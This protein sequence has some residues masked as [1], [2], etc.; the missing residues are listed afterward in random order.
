MGDTMATVYE[1]ALKFALYADERSIDAWFADLNIEE[2][3]VCMYEHEKG[4]CALVEDAM[5][6]LIQD[7]QDEHIEIAEDQEGGLDDH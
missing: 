7:M 4:K 5:G 3:R 2:K 6:S 1:E